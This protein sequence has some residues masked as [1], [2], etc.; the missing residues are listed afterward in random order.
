M[1]SLLEPKLALHGQES[2]HVQ[3]CSEPVAVYLR[4]PL[5]PGICTAEELLHTGQ[6]VASELQTAAGGM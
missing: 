2:L 3:I 6:P 1:Q 4:R 5:A